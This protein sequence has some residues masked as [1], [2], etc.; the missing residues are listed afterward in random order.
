MSSKKFSNL[1]LVL[2]AMCYGMFFMMQSLNRIGRDVASVKMLLEDC[3]RE[4]EKEKEKEV[5][6]KAKKTK[7]AKEAE[8]E[9][10]SD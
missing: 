10:E 7:K 8:S 9:G 5:K 6:A 2:L 1:V 4:K 3:A